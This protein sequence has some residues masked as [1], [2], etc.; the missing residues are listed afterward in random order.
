MKQ[1]TH[2]L[3]QQ[4]HNRKVMMNDF[5]WLPCRLQRGYVFLK[6]THSNTG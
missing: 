1:K 2:Y 4:L 6:Q 5:K 3:I